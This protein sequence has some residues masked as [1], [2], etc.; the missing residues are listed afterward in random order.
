M[1]SFSDFIL[2]TYAWKGK[3]PDEGNLLKSSSRRNIRACGGANQRNQSDC[4]YPYPC[5]PANRKLLKGLTYGPPRLLVK[6]SQRPVKHGG[7]HGS[8]QTEDTSRTFQVL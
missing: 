4:L 3:H 1:C 8:E 2:E 5:C 6:D 7:M